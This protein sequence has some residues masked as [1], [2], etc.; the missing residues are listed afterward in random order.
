MQTAQSCESDESPTPFGGKRL[1]RPPSREL[2]ARAG[3]IGGSCVGDSS[4][5]P[6]L[7]IAAKVRPILALLCIIQCDLRNSL[8]RV[9]RTAGF[10][11]YSIGRAAPRMVGPS[12]LPCSHRHE[13]KAAL[14]RLIF[15]VRNRRTLTLAPSFPHFASV[16]VARNLNS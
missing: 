14:R 4:S 6:R 15:V 8:A 9:C 10:Y 16:N 2:R 1:N 5:S 11:R 3:E 12:F 13:V 7:P